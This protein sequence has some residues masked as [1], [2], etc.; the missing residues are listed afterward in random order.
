MLGMSLQLTTDA[1]PVVFSHGYQCPH[2]GE[3]HVAD[4]TELWC[5]IAMQRNGYLMRTAR[6]AKKCVAIRCP[7]S[8]G[9]KSRAACVAECCGA[10][11]SHREDAYILP[12]SKSHTFC[13]LVAH[14]WTGSYV[15][16]ELTAPDGRRM[17][18]REAKKELHHV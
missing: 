8:S 10:R 14:G 18:Y 6:Y 3:R 17:T 9:Y 7:S 4:D 13:L 1:P 15:L 5:A 12:A 16:N 11:W 2:C